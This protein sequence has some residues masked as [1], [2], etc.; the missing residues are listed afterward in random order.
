M[1]AGTASGWQ[2]ASTTTWTL[3]FTHRRRSYRLR[4]HHQ[5]K[6]AVLEAHGRLVEFREFM[7]TFEVVQQVLDRQL[8]V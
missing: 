4:A 7:N 3:S 8:A 6:G 5:G 1:R 2:L